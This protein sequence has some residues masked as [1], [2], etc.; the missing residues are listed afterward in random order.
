VGARASDLLATPLVELH[1]G[2]DQA[3]TE[4]QGQPAGSADEPDAQGTEIGEE[5]P[6]AFLE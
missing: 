5:R 6:D 3:R 1:G 4:E 2:E